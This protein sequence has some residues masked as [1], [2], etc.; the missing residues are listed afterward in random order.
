MFSLSKKT[1][2]GL[3]A[4]TY[5]SSLP[6]GQLANVTEIAESSEIPR[7]LL[8]KILSELVKAGLTTSLSGPTGGFCL[9]RPA[10]HITLA[11]IIRAL[12]SR[13][14]I[15]GCAEHKDACS[16]SATCTIR[17]PMT[18]VKKRVENVLKETTLVD[19]LRG[20]H[21]ARHLV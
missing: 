16:R 19:F 12:E 7:E 18:V 15:I 6:A 10:Q 8:A 9:A 4:L 17:T 3:L 14:A 13:P 21:Q 11:D 5:L 2:Y 20:H 1:E